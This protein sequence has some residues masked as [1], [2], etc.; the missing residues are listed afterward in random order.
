MADLPHIIITLH[1]QARGSY[2]ASIE[3]HQRW[4]PINP[5]QEDIAEGPAPIGEITCIHFYDGVYRTYVWYPPA[6]PEERTMVQRLVC[7]LFGIS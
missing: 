1:D 6:P 4:Q 3:G 5:D 7:W 2:I